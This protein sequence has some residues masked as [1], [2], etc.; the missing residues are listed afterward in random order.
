MKKIL[1]IS[2]LSV[3]IMSLFAAPALVRAALSPKDACGETCARLFPAGSFELSQCSAACAQPTKAQCDIYCQTNLEGAQEQACLIA[4]LALDGT[5]YATLDMRPDSGPSPLRADCFANIYNY[6]DTS[7]PFDYKID[8][9]SDDSWDINKEKDGPSEF[10]E[11]VCCVYTASATAKLEVTERS[12]SKKAFATAPV[13]I[14]GD[15]PQPPG[16]TGGACLTTADC[17]NSGEICDFSTK[18][19]IAV[20]ASSPV[21]SVSGIDDLIRSVARWIAILIS[22]IAVIFIILGGVSYITAG[23]DEEKAKGAKNKIIYGL[24]GLG[25]AALA[26]GAEALVRSALR[27]GQ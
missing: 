21:T 6:T 26:W 3:F 14:T 20:S 2:I 12:T 23:G 5:L 15:E 8:C 18:T 4:C 16:P 25:V 22:I 27:L 11:A 13:T 10:Y 9:T 7:A 24:I 19:C 17:K 1:G